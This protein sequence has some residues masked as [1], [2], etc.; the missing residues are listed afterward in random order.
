MRDPTYAII[1][2]NGRPCFKDCLAAVEHQVDDVIVIEG[3]P[4]ARLFGAISDYGDHSFA[5]IREPELNISKWWNLGLNLVADRA[6]ENRWSRWN[7][8]IL[9]DDA[10]L[11]AG[12]VDVVAAKMRQM[13]AAAGCTG[14]PNPIP[15]FHTHAGQVDLATRMQGYAFMLA[16]EKGVRANEQLKWYFS[17]DHVDWASRQLGGMVS[18]PG[19]HVRHLYPN[20]Q[21]TPEVQKMIAEDATKF[22]AY[23]GAR[24]W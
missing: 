24:P 19:Y 22:V 7:V 2:T 11:P 8:V 14:N 4:N 20:S 16:G 15:A 10:L 23:W 9:N 5:I 21:V 13:Y 18:I 3:G 1:P 17:D 6:R 12:W